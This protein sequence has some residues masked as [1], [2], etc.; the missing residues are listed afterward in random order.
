MLPLHDPISNLVFSM[1]PENVVHTL[2]GGVWLMRDRRLTRI[3]L[4]ALLIEAQGRADAIRNR[5]GIR[6][7]KRFN[8]S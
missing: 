2:A 7:P 1:K 5:A 3:D 8:W 4:P 6:L